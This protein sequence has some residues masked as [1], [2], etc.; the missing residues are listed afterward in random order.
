LLGNGLYVIAY[1]L[2]IGIVYSQK[3]LV[4]RLRH[5]KHAMT[6][7]KADPLLSGGR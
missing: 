6:R 2:K 1:P 5:C 3:T 4:A 7:F